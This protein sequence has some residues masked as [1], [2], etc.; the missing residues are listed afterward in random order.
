M[1][2]GRNRLPHVILPLLRLVRVRV[3]SSLTL[4]SLRDVLLF[5]QVLRWRI[6]RRP[7]FLLPASAGGYLHYRAG[8]ATDDRDIYVT[9]VLYVLRCWWQHLPAAAQEMKDHFYKQAGLL[10]VLFRVLLFE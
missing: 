4:L 1:P 9:I 7:S 5:F 2:A 8:C 6:W 3:T 10:Q